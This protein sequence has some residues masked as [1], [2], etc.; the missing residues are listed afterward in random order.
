M[1]EKEYIQIPA[2]QVKITFVATCIEAT[3]RVTGESYQKVFKEMERLGV[4]KDYIYK[5]YETLHTE[6]RENIVKDLL[7]YM[8]LK[9][10]HNNE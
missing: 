4:I 7:S 1:S 8:E 9:K 2:E 3:A 6:S 5:N 10:A